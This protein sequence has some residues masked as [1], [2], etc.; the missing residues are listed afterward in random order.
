[1]QV[2]VPAPP[3]M[4]APENPSRTQPS[5]PVPSL[6]AV[7]LAAGEGSRMRSE[8]PKPL[9]RLCGRPMLMYVL[10]S[11]ADVDADRAVIVV[12]HKGEWVTKKMQEHNHGR[13]IDFV[14]QR[15]QR[16]TGDATM[17][18][19]VGLPD[20]DDEERCAGDD[21]RRPAAAARDHRLVGRTPPVERCRRHPPDG[22]DGRPDRLRPGRARSRRLGAADRRTVRCHRRGAGHRRGEHLDLLLPS[23][24]PGPGAAAGA[25]RTTRRASTT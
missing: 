23:G 12:G 16:G 5:G 25:A 20:D 8:R 14:E 9:H 18:G 1:M 10:D 13:E 21:R 2:R 4:T 11:L 24:A 6:S 3:A 19:L 17:V 22:P 15:V 7:V